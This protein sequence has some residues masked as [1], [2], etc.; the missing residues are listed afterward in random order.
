[1]MFRNKGKVYIVLT[2]AVRWSYLLQYNVNRLESWSAEDKDPRQK[3]Y[4]VQP[5]SLEKMLPTHRSS[6]PT[7]ASHRFS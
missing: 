2:K 1:M 4:A 3:Q 5:I 7:P 6:L